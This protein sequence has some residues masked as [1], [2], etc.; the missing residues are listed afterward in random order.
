MSG[1]NPSKFW[2]AVND[3]RA[4]IAKLWRAFDG[5]GVDIQ[6]LWSASHSQN[7]NE[8]ELRTAI[9]DLADDIDRIDRQNRPHGRGESDLRSARFR[10]RTRRLP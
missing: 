10:R 5:H 9:R 2:A 3:L 4:G 1:D 7:A 8:Q 6:R